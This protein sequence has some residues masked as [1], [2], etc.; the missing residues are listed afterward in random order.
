[1]PRKHSPDN[2]SAVKITPV[3]GRKDMAEFIELPWKIYR[4]NPLWAPPLKSAQAKLF[5]RKKHPFW[6]FSRGEFFLARRGNETVGRILAIIDGNYNQYHSETIAAWGFFECL[7]D[8]EAAMALFQ[9]VEQWATREGMTSLRGPLNPSTNYEIGL[10]VQGFDKAPALMMTYN[11][12]YYLELVH[13]AGF[14][15]EKDLFSYHYTSDM[16]L[17]DWMFSLSEKLCRQGDVE[18]RYLKKWTRDDIHLLCS[19]YHECWKNNWGFV[20]TTRE[21]EVELA[22]D[23]LPI[24]EPKFA[25]FIYHRDVLAG[26]C[27][28]LPDFNPLLKH[29]NGNL[30]ISALFKKMLYESE[31]TGLRALLFGIKEP[32]RQMGLPL[33]AFK[34]LNELF[35]EMP[36]YRYAELGWSLEDN[37]AMNRLYEDA[38][39]KPDKRYRI[40]R[41]ELC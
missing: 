6:S 4:D 40:Y 28:F 9:Q 14:R 29:F 19:V 5:N 15:K 8:P 25:F 38:G 37:D 23:L 11:P 20:P 7:N 26:I 12:P 34:Y 21:E 13:G 22:K 3:Q 35:Q 17:P 36:R 39:L 1:M 41:K 33:L 10:L 2:S 16:Q 27:L 32:F 30:G 18:I 31:I 24:L